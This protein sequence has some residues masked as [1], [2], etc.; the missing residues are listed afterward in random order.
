M[1]QIVVTGRGCVSALGLNRIA[2]ADRLLRGESAIGPITLFDAAPLQIK[3]A[4]Q[5][6][7]YQGKEYFPDNHLQQLDRF[8]QFGL[9]ATREAVA[10]A[11]IDFAGPLAQRTA[12]VVGTGAGGQE[13]LE[14]GYHRLFVQNAKR[15]HPFT[16]PKSIPSSVAS[17]IS[18]AYGITGPVFVT[19]SACSS[20]GHAIGMALMLLRSGL[21]DVAITG[22]AEACITYGTIRAWEGLRVMAADTCRPFC[23]QRGGMVIGEGAGILVL[24]TRDH[25]QTR[26]AAILAELAGFGMSSDANNMLQPLVDG[27]VQAMTAALR[28]AGLDPDAIDYINAH[29]TGTT[30]ND[31]TETQAIHKVFGG[32]AARLAISS[33]KSMH[34]HTLGA[35]AAMESIACLVALQHQV[36]PPTANFQDPDPQCDL[37]CL[38]NLARSMRVRA[39]LNNSFAFGGLNTSLLF[40][41]CTS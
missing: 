23:L 41:H 9:L 10:E 26:G 29:G 2:F 13:T 34:G 1:R 40:K 21:V 38:P 4:A 11:N 7:G 24:E 16:V 12:V 25:A 14:Q 35:A 20:A 18:I 27:P 32:H 5:V 28:D 6:P 33:T 39:V 30:A 19:S 17:Q 3:V 36:A 8:A 15:L 37:D 31:T 22:G